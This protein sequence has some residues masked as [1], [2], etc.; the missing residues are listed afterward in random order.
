MMADVMPVT[1]QTGTPAPPPAIQLRELKVR[2]D[3][4]CAAVKSL[5]D[6]LKKRQIAHALRMTTG[7]D[8]DT[9]AALKTCGEKL[10][11]AEDSLRE[12]EKKAVEGAKELRSAADEQIR[13]LS[14]NMQTL[15]T[16]T[17][18]QTRLEQTLSQI[19]S[20]MLERTE[21]QG[22]EVAAL[23]NIV[24][25][26]N[27]LRPM[28]DS[29]PGVQTALDGVNAAIG[30]IPSNESVPGPNAGSL[31][32][33][34]QSAVN[35]LLTK[36]RAEPESRAYSAEVERVLGESIRTLDREAMQS[37]KTRSDLVLYL[38]ELESQLAQQADV[39]N[40]LQQS[41]QE[42]AQASQTAS[43]G[44]A[45]VEEL[46]DQVRLLGFQHGEC[47]ANLDKCTKRLIDCEAAKIEWMKDKARLEAA[48]VTLQNDLNVCD[49]RAKSLSDQLEACKS[50]SGAL[51]K[52]VADLKTAAEEYTREAEAKQAE[53]NDVAEKIKVDL[54]QAQDAATAAN[55]AMD[56]KDADYAIALA[57]ASED[58]ARRLKELADKLD[59]KELERADAQERADKAVADASEASTR[60]QSE[61]S[62]WDAKKKTLLDGLE[63]C[64][65]DKKRTEQQLDAALKQLQECNDSKPAD[66]TTVPGA[67]PEVFAEKQE[68][69]VIPIAHSSAF[70][71]AHPGVTDRASGTS[72]RTIVSN[73][74]NNG[75]VDSS[76]PGVTDRVSGTSSG[77][78][79]SNA[80]N[81][82]AVDSS[83]PG[84]IDRASGTSSRTIVSNAANNGTVDS[85]RP[86]VID[87][88][89]GT[90]SGTIVSNAANNGAVDSS[91]PG[92]T[93]R[94]SG[95]SSGTIVSNAAN[96][97]AVD[98]S[99]PG[100]I[101]R[102]SGTSSG[103]IVSNAANNGA[104]D[105][106]RPGVTDRASGT[107]SRTTVSNAANNGTVDS[108]R[109]GVIDRASG[110]SSGTIVSNA[111][112]N[113][114]VDSSRPGVT[115]R[116]SGTS[117]GTTGSVARRT[118][119]QQ[120]QQ[121]Q[122]QPAISGTISDTEMAERLR[123]AENAQK[124]EESRSSKASADEQEEET[125]FPSAMAGIDSAP[126]TVN[127]IRPD[128]FGETTA[129][130][131]PN[132]TRTLR[133]EADTNAVNLEDLS[134]NLPPAPSGLFSAQSVATPAIEPDTSEV[135][136]LWK[137]A[138]KHYRNRAPCAYAQ[139]QSQYLKQGQSM[140]DI[141]QSAVDVARIERIPC[142]DPGTSP[143]TRAALKNLST[144]IWPTRDAFSAIDKWML[145]EPARLVTTTGG[146]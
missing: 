78:I 7:D 109:P 73:A 100:V 119:Q 11:S 88:A 58:A 49:T 22:T 20:D 132:N 31:Y 71:S 15:Q 23:S 67:H 142:A 77:T 21:G 24:D 43:S 95:T 139:F 101:D 54:R 97:G 51:E 44:N 3:E 94:A 37:D 116:A 102:A 55:A 16:I 29:F 115:D 50:A 17:E 18:N 60:L 27:A 84:V 93:D 12:Y 89:S 129:L 141:L 35:R 38:K 72:S 64:E 66:V 124:Q 5:K 140:Q 48:S 32:T 104:V 75:A 68:E 62:E 135:D 85:S 126:S 99:R 13:A 134:V 1:T 103:T 110:T 87:R 113:G 70:T 112:N 8:R 39:V 42:C 76:R 36:L 19:S 74:A 138:A 117:S 61:S 80:A 47:T 14:T 130:I 143:L 30:R 122:Q 40:S 98:S 81:N 111:A 9:R 45:V 121:Q 4:R 123:N 57:A 79:V 118:G 46:R 83:R 105:S 2:L 137:S 82:G 65:N 136:N 10:R 34:L 53:L 69:Q 127:D 90:S 146:A 59:Q 128:T 92:V 125:V 28:G 133:R 120:Q 96:N 63:A 145:L 144:E 6:E 26:I 25:V 91:R 56:G 52:T 41:L 131:A 106:S 86:G 108:S 114:A 33:D 107:S